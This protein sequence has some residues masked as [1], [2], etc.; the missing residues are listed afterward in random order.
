MSQLKE[1]FK[2]PDFEDDHNPSSMHDIIT[3]GIDE[4]RIAGRMKHWTSNVPE[5]TDNSR[6]FDIVCKILNEHKPFKRES[7]ANGRKI[8]LWFDVPRTERP[9]DIER[10]DQTVL[11]KRFKE[12]R[13]PAYA[14]GSESNGTVLR[15]HVQNMGSFYYSNITTISD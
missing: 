3:R 6:I 14:F 7:R 5:P 4:N 2:S 9:L 13:V 11:I 1:L 8:I 10:C 12:M 15:I